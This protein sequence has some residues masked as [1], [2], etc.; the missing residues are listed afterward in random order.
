MTWRDTP[1]AR[2]L[3]LRVPLVQ[4]PMAGG[5]TT[6]QLVAEVCRAGGLGSVAGAMLSPDE[7]RAQIRAVRSLTSAPFAVNLFA[8]SPAPS[9]DR[10]TSSPSSSRSGFRCSA[11]PSACPRWPAWTP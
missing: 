9:P 2:R 11:S 1:F 6:P 3:G 8:P 10:A 7:L 4:A 5:S